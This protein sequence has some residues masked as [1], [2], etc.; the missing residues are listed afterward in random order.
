MLDERG[1]TRDQWND[2]NLHL[3]DESVRLLALHN[4][5]LAIVEESPANGSPVRNNPA[6]LRIGYDPYESGLL[7]RLPRRRKRDLRELSRWM[8]MKRRI[9]PTPS[10]D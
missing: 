2:Q 9:G 6:G 1:N 5:H 7:T 4:P 3:E 8:E 10:E